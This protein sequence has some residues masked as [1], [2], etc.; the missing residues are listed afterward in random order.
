MN[1]TNKIFIFPE[2]YFAPNWLAKRTAKDSKSKETFFRRSIRYINQ[3]YIQTF[4]PESFR[5]VVVV[6]S[7]VCVASRAMMMLFD[8]VFFSS[9]TRNCPLMEKEQNQQPKVWYLNSCNWNVIFLSSTWCFNLTHWGEADERCCPIPTTYSDNLSDCEH[10][11]V[12][13]SHSDNKNWWGILKTRLDQFISIS[14]FFRQTT[15]QISR[16]I[17]AEAMLRENSFLDILFLLDKNR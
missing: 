13:L 14:T 7:G 9:G 17:R 3:K 8:I 10:L 6:V 12:C 4:A 15:E 2:Q 5:V 16:K 11:D 1:F